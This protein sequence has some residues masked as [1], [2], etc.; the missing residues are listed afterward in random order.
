MVTIKLGAESLHAYPPRAGVPAGHGWGE[1]DALFKRT[2]EPVTF[3]SLD[4][5]QAWIDAHAVFA[6]GVVIVEA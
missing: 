3:V 4:A 2:G 6:S 1:W 5:A